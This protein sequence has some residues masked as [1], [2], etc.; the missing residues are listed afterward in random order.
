MLHS[1]MVSN[2]LMTLLTFNSTQTNR[3]TWYRTWPD[4]ITM[5][6]VLSS[7]STAVMRFGRREG[8]WSDG[9]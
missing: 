6:G 8:R 1:G 3:Q 7:L 4:S 9:I 2:T 5:T